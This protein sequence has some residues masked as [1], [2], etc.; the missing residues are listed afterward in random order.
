[1]NASKFAYSQLFQ[2][3]G[4][5]PVLPTVPSLSQLQ[6]LQQLSQLGQFPAPALSPEQLQGYLQLLRPGLSGP[7]FHPAA[8][9]TT[10]TNSKVITSSVT[11]TESEEYRWGESDDCQY[12]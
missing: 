9:F 10:I 11:V 4:S 8:V 6:Q 2:F 12:D 7:A 1:M 5:T 3:P